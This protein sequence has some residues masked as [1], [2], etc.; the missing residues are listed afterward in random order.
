MHTHN[1]LEESLNEVKIKG[2][3][4]QL[5]TMETE[6]SPVVTV[7]GK[8][9]IMA[10]SNNYLGLAADE[11]VKKAATLAIQEFGVGSS[12]S[13]LT[14]GNTRLHMKLEEKVA[15]FKQ[16]EACLLFSSGYLANVGVISSLVGKEDCILSDELNH[17]S[18]IDGCRLSKGKT[19]V[20][21]HV[22]MNDLEKKLQEATHYR[23]RFIVTDGVFSMDG[24][25]A[26]LSDIVELAKRYDAFV[27]VDDAHA[28]GVIGR[29]GRGTSEYFG[30]KVDA[31]IG[32]LSKAVGAEGGFVV[33]AKQ[34]I[35]YLRNK[36]RTFIF[37]TGLSPAVVQA[38]YQAFEIIEHEPE[39][40][41]KLHHLQNELR[42]K[43]REMGYQVLGEATPIV[44]VIIGGTEEALL[45][46]EKLKEEGI[47]APAIRPPT[48]PEGTS[49][50]RLTLMASFR[51][52]HIDR[53]VNAFETIGKCVHFQ[54]C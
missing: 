29:N 27:I 43:L 16:E 15:K 54:K 8:T 34:L 6:P 3:Y 46:A 26:P 25:I 20:Y 19:I 47:F 36:A 53:I 7:D 12:G 1:W 18:I 40:R 35:D 45:F 33:G 2:L 22:D 49:R 17:A 24:N 32:T 14:T 41:E 21:Q 9:Y 11:R 44:P 39:R 37:Q 30:V 48:V 52:E 23:R 38:A 50:I 13:R 42:T 10:A 51:E 28:T 31:T 4:R 5:K